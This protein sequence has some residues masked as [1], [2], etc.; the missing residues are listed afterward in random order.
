V[1]TEAKPIR[2]GERVAGF[3][4]AAGGAAGGGGALALL[5]KYDHRSRSGNLV[6]AVPG[7]PPADLGP[8]V[9]SFDFSPSG[10]YVAYLQRV[11]KPIFTQELWVA[12]TAAEP[13][14]RRVEQGVY[15]LQF[16]A[17]DALLGFKA[18]CRNNAS[19][20]TL[21]T[22]NPAGGEPRERAKDVAGFDFAPD[23]R[24]VLVMKPFRGASTSAVEVWVFPSTGGE[25]L[26]LAD[27]ATPSA[28][29]VDAG[30]VLYSAPPFAPSPGVYLADL[31]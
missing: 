12:R 20:C 31:P 8:G 11:L 26:L 4:F 28:R 16:A 6:V 1:G 9:V 19:S 27:A 2:V 25:G 14:P 5:A 24:R 3:R 17:G 18:R 30:R 7:A 22:V 29:W 13:A 21:F 15:G 10:A 23:G